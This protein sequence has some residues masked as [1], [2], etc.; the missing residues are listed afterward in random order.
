V[1]GGAAIGLLSGSLC[2]L[3]A[4]RWP[5]SRPTPEASPSGQ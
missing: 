2:W 1:V 5:I 3:V 4:G